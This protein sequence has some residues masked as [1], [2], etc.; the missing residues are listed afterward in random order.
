MTAAHVDVDVTKRYGAKLVLDRFR[1]AIGQGEF[2]TLLG[3]SGCGKSTALG[4]IAGLLDLSEGAVY[5]DGRRIDTVP[6]ERRGIGLVFQNYALFPHLTVFRNVGF[7]LEI[8]GVPRADRAR[9]VAEM[10]ALVRLEGLGDRYPSQL[11]GGQ[12]QRVAIAR[13]LVLHPP[14]ILFDEPLSNLDAKLRTEMR[15]EIRRLHTS[16]GLTTVYVTHDQAEALS[17]SDTVVVMKDGR[18]QQAGP[19]AEVFD[20]PA[21]RF[22]ADFM[23]FRNFLPVTPGLGGATWGG[24]TLA[25]AAPVNGAPLL[26]IRPDDIVLGAEGGP[27]ELDGEVEMVEYLGRERAVTVR[28]DGGDALY[29]RTAEAVRAGERITLTL[30][31]GALLPLA[32]GAT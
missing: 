7:G 12:Q 11:S 3:P 4:C 10:L 6:M 20:R 13:A 18:I 2:V 26:A 29:L 19:P 27:N 5:M 32:D 25:V 17:I 21:N 16:L 30:P 8:K 1:L 14:L 28:L 22:V 24:R 31:P 15:T 23:G 9:R